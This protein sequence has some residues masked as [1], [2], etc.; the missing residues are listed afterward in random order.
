MEV[1]FLL[2]DQ[3]LKCFEAASE[4]YSSSESFNNHQLIY[5]LVSCNELQ[6]SSTL[7]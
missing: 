3:Y 5:H 6:F 2:V 7:A 4:K 1:N